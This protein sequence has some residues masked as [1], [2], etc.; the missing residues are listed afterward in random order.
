[1][2]QSIRNERIRK[3]RNKYSYPAVVA[4]EEG[5]SEL[6]ETYT[7]HQEHMTRLLRS[8][9]NED[10]VNGYL[11]IVFWGFYSGADSRVRAE[12]AWSRYKMA[13]HGQTRRVNGRLI[14]IQ[15]VE[16]LGD[17][18]VCG[19]VRTA[20]EHIELREY[21]SALAT[22]TELPQ[23]KYAFA[24]KVC[25]FLK[26]SECGVLDSVIAEAHPELNMSTDSKGIIRYNKHNLVIYDS[27][28]MGLQRKALDLNQSPANSTW[29]DLDGSD[30]SWCSLD[31][32]RGLYAT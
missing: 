12:R 30:C 13:R 19:I 7:A 17:D 5:Q 26:P 23:S 10:I 27:Y 22:L 20:T 2:F 21:S 15:G 25:A 32:E 28:C 24:S 18:A 31:V 9:S 8:D 11:S 16:Q 29:R 3:N 1:M 4:L 14:N 6:M